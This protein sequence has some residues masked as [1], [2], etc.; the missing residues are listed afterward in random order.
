MRKVFEILE[1]LPYAHI[2]VSIFVLLVNLYMDAEMTWR[3]FY[4]SYKDC[5][6]KTY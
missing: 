1:H 6:K 5:K 4:S 2:F 3:L